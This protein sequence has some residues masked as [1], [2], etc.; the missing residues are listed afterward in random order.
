MIEAPVTPSDADAP[1]WIEDERARIP[2]D[3]MVRGFVIADVLAVAERAGHRLRPDLA[4]SL[5][6]TYP[7]TL[8][9]D[10]LV[11][12]ARRV[13]PEL[14]VRDAIRRIARTTF[15]ALASTSLGRAIFAAAG[16]QVR[17]LLWLTAQGFQLSGSRNATA[18]LVGCGSDSAVLRIENCPAL[19][20]SAVAG[21]VEGLLEA[22]QLDF[23]VRAERHSPTEGYLYLHWRSA[24]R[25]V[26]HHAGSAYP[27]DPSGSAHPA[28][29]ATKVEAH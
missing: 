22:C 11:E 2:A 1:S 9:L 14:P 7:A 3:A 25:A 29:T 26:R 19:L 6:K 23:E 8:Y 16:R 12:A 5:W 27:H 20:E 10:V 21:G 4:I 13:H 15:T 18:E 17:P 24:P 28:H